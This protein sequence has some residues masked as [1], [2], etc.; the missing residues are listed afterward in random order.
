MEI[1]RYLTVAFGLIDILVAAWLSM[2]K[3]S[4][5]PA[6]VPLDFYVIPFSGLVLPFNVKN[7]EFM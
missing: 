6:T 5:H 4:V 3:S 7:M 2:N 1:L